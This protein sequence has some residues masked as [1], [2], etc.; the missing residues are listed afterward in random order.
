MSSKTLIKKVKILDEAYKKRIA[1]HE[2]TF[3]PG[4]NLLIGSNGSGKSTLLSMLTKRVKVDSKSMYVESNSGTFYSFDFEKDNPRI[5]A[6]VNGLIDVVSRFNSHGE[7]VIAILD[8]L[9]SEEVEN[10]LI[11]MDEPEQ[12]LDVEAINSFID[13]VTKSS[14]SQ[15]II[16]TH[17]P[18]LILNPVFNIVE[19]TPGYYRLV[20]DCVKRCVELNS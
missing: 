14:A 11:F 13:I 15:M 20:L 2:L 4:P 8:R 6:Q 1:T 9:I 10:S 5:S 12:A 7:T 19:M 18:L 16:A 3:E 17:H